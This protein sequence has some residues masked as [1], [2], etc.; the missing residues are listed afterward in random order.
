MRNHQ[1]IATLLIFLAI[2]RGLLY[3]S[4]FPP[5]LAPDEAT[6]FEA[7]RLI[8]QEGKW[9]TRDVYLTTPMHPQ[10]HTSFMQFHIWE[11]VSVPVPSGVL[12]HGDPSNDPYILY[13]PAQ[14]GGSIVDADRY[15]LLYHILLSPLSSLVKGLGIVAQ[16]YL[17]RLISLLFF[18]LII[19]VGWLFARVIFPTQPGYAIAI[20][21]FLLFLPMHVHINTSV[22]TDALVA[23]LV[24]TFFLFLA[25][26]FCNGFS[27]FR[28]IAL[29]VFLL[30][31][32]LTKPTALFLIPTTIVSIIVFMARY[33]QWKLRF[34][35][36]IIAGL[37]LFTFFASIIIFQT[38]SGGHNLSSF[39]ASSINFDQHYSNI[40]LTMFPHFIRWSFVSFWGLFGWANIALPFSWV[41]LLWVICFACGAGLLIFFAQQYFNKGKKKIMLERGQKD[42]LLVLLFGLVFA[43]F[44]IYVPFL[45]TQ[46]QT[47]SPQS[48]YFFPALL[49][50]AL[51][52]FLGF[53]HLFPARMQHFSVII[54]LTGLIFFDTLTV[55]S[56][57]IPFIYG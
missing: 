57:L 9:P 15:S 27:I 45:A 2:I 49:P 44:S 19:L 55:F 36:W 26:I 6:H 46:S 13:Y 5:W 50:F 53:R 11:I 37:V 34:V 56:V 24:A 8:G 39:S 14:N 48:R 35:I 41:R 3:I 4:I 40:F 42:L 25:T 12:N 52:F 21:A 20:A 10:M 16:L 54:W 22:N 18:V 7:I 28:G 30:L 29:G 43:G 51:F 33:F 47:W 38:T 17:L 1:K 23:L 31:A 32:I